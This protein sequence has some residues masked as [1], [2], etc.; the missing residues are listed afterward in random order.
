M[1]EVKTV[2]EFFQNLARRNELQ[3]DI[4]C[5]VIGG[6]DFIVICKSCKPQEKVANI[7]VV[8]LGIRED[9]T[10]EKLTYWDIG[11]GNKEEFLKHAAFNPDDNPFVVYC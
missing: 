8:K 3:K 10:G 9:E 11:E 4:L 1:N 7:P 6:Y 5:L 2:G